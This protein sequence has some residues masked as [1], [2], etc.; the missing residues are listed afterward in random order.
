MHTHSELLASTTA[1]ATAFIA[2]NPANTP[3]DYLPALL[4]TIYSTLS[5]LTSEPPAATSPPEPAKLEP[6]VPI[7]KSVTPDYI[8]CLDDGKKLKMLKRHLAKLGMTPDEYRRKWGLPVDYPMTAPNYAAVR[9]GLAKSYGL[10]K[11]QA[12]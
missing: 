11:K 8:V 7:R 3:M 5:D 10:G 9:S 1:V 4:K 12:A 2:A 6:A